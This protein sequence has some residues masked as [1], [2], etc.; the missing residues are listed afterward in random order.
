PGQ[1]NDPSSQDSHLVWGWLVQEIA[2]SNTLLAAR[3][4]RR[5]HRQLATCDR[6]LGKFSPHRALAAYTVGTLEFQRG[7]SAT[8]RRWFHVACFEDFRT[9]KRGAARTALLA[10]LGETPQALDELEVLAGQV[11]RPPGTL[12]AEPEY[13][14]TK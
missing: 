7:D 12:D 5:W 13:V 6:A 4:A 1:S 2:K 3:V 10:A 14:I 9:G 8:A 11:S